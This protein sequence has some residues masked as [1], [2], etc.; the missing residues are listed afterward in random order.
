MIDPLAHVGRCQT[1]FGPRAPAATVTP[2]PKCFK[3]E[4]TCVPIRVRIDIGEPDQPWHTVG[5]LD[6]VW[7]HCEAEWNGGWEVSVY[8][9]TFDED[10]ELSVSGCSSDCISD[11]VARFAQSDECLAELTR[12]AVDLQSE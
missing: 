11:A 9:W 2:R 4:F 5:Y 10:G 3:I 7:A 1:V 8:S 12:R 6:A